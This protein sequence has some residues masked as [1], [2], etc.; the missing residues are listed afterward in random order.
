MSNPLPS[1]KEGAA[2]D[3]AP[4]T[5][6]EVGVAKA[7]PAQNSQ[8]SLTCV[9]KEES[10]SMIGERGMEKGGGSGAAEEE[11][12]RLMHPSIVPSKL[13]NYL[14]QTHAQYIILCH[15][16]NVYVVKIETCPIQACL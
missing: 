12:L 7:E 15:K 10:D 16:Y 5:G 8:D 1:N 9:K 2:V 6:A 3:K 4:P 11:L 14:M 13:R